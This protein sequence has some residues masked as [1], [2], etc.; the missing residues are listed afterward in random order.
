LGGDGVAA[1][2]AAICVTIAPLLMGMAATFNTTALD[3]VAWTLITLCLVHAARTGKGRA[4]WLCGLIAGINLEIK[5]SLVL[6]CVCLAVGLLATPERKLLFRKD[7]WI[8]IA[9]AAIIAVPSVIWQALHG[10]P[11]LELAAAAKAKN[12]ETPPVAFLLNQILI[13]SPLLAPVWISGL[14]GP[15]VIDRL[16]VMRFVPIAFVV[17]AL[18][19]MVSHGKDYYLG[20]AYPVLFIMGAVSIAHWIKPV[21]GRI[22]LAGWGVAAIAFSA[23]ISPLALPV[24]TVPELKTF[25]EHFPLK[26]QQQEKSFAGT[27]LPQVFADQLGWRDFTDQVGTAWNQIPASERAKTA[28]KVDNYGEAAALDIYGKPYGLPPTLS[29]HNQYY[30]WGLRGQH[31]VHLLVVQNH[32]ERLYPYCQKTTLYRTTF[33]PDAMHSENGKIIAWCQGLKVD[34]PTLWPELKHM[35]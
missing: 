19:V 22:A 26:P 15:F 6:W 21:W 9:I 7:M 12:A 3:P 24:L 2:G 23:W 17:F 35:D 28:I 5:Y 10:F 13:M 8:G 1:A 32:P 31:P 34:L 20:A 25:I 14:V 33:S 11:F 18:F 27:L 4:L 30:F 29:G 16:R